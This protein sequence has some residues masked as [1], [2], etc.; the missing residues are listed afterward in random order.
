MFFIVADPLVKRIIRI[1]N[2]N[3]GANQRN[4]DTR[5]LRAR[6][7]FVALQVC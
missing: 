1:S 2:L 7:L 5:D 6:N 3:I 4:L